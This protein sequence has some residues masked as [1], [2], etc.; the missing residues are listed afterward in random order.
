MK[1]DLDS[2]L[3][4]KMI[5]RDVEVISEPKQ[6]PL[7][8]LTLCKLSEPEEYIL[9]LFHNGYFGSSVICTK[10]ELTKLRDNL[11]SFLAQY[12]GE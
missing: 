4:D 5:K 3:E 9:R 1:T 11:T 12:G 7:V 6:N 10:E 2:Y 8:T